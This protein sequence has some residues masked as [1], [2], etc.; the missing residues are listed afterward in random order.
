MKRF[1]TSFEA[2]F[3]YKNQQMVHEAQSPFFMVHFK[4]VLRYLSGWSHWSH[5]GR[6]S[7]VE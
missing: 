4:Q 2:E 1:F 6:N 5:L 3:K 7:K